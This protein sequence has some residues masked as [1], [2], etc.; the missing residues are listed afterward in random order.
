MKLTTKCL[1][2]P[3]HGITGIQRS[4]KCNLSSHHCSSRIKFFYSCNVTFPEIYDTV[5]YIKRPHYI[6][7][8]TSTLVHITFGDFLLK[9]LQA[10]SLNWY[11]TYSVNAYI[12]T[13]R[14]TLSQHFMMKKT[15]MD[16]M[17]Q[18][19]HTLYKLHNIQSI[20]DDIKFM[21]ETVHY[22]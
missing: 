15:N 7:K 20:S 13:N 17:D 10:R 9:V 19:D 12:H 6:V 11:I 8:G 1:I 21:H 14:Q 3:C 16:K 5:P 2:I 18:S 4:S 22:H